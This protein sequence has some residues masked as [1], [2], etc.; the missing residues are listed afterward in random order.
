MFFPYDTY[1]KGQMEFVDRVYAALV[2]KKNLIVHA[3]TGLGKSVSIIAPT[4][5]YMLEN[6]DKKLCLWFLTPK[7][8]QHE[9]IIE[10]LKL[11]KNKFKINFDVV[12]LIG[13]KWMCMQGNVLNMKNFEFNEYCMG[14]V[15]NDQC[16]FYNN[17]KRNNKISVDARVLLGRLYG[18]ILDVEQFKEFCGDANLCSFE[19]ACLKGKGVQIIIGD[20]Y[21]ILSKDIRDAIFAR[22]D[23]NL[24]KC[25]VV[26][27]EAHNLAERAR[28]LLSQEL[29]LFLL[30]SCISELEFNGDLGKGNILR[31]I[32]DNFE[33]FVRDRLSLENNEVIVKMEDFFELVNNIVDYDQL[34]V[35]LEEFGRVM[36][37][38]G[39]NTYCLELREFLVFWRLQIEEG[40]IRLIKR[41]FDSNGK[42]YYSL[43][44]KC[45]DPSFI[46][47]DI[48]ETAHNVIAMS[49]TLKPGAMYMDLW[50]VKADILEFENPF[51][52]ENKLSII[53]PSVSTKFT[54]RDD[55]MYNKIAGI[56]AG[57]V[58]KVPGNCAVFFPSYNI[59]E[60]IYDYLFDLIDKKTIFCEVQGMHKA[61]KQELLE[62]F[63]AN[64]NPGSILLGVS[65]GSLGEGVDYIGDYLKCV[66]IVGLP[67]A[68]PN[69]E[70]RK[71][72]DY[73]DFKYGKGWDYGY[74]LPAVIKTMQ[75]AG[76]CIRSENDRGVV[77][78]LDERYVW[79]I[80]KKCFNEDILVNNNPFQLIDD[81]FKAVIL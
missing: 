79:P 63:K 28:G 73:Y 31:E 30:N 4:L 24:S 57:I 39:K 43:E 37:E 9:I 36:I 68:K 54:K 41:N 56:V 35:D 59:L 27:D 48:Y 3:P 16:M 13:K 42:V 67:L 23:Q 53:V 71:L 81:F 69:L 7:H 1:R 29:N 45:L 80:Y 25:I 38:E 77:I 70:T 62:R 19:M 26:F 6:K 21:H 5:T 32:K 2:N 60:K 34:V 52:K 74:S 14:L 8:S 72:I 65:S 47:K 50:G 22:M 44:Y 33:L 64:N 49:G 17:I 78:Y 75:N 18:N 55:G 51:P 58:N 61:E 76:R 11:I 15:K 66:I 40:F 46:L 10:T 20:Y 12:D